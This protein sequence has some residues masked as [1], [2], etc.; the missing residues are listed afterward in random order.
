MS[1]AK[2][3]A[4][5]QTFTPVILPAVLGALVKCGTE[6][7]A[8]AGRAVEMEQIIR[9][10][11]KA[12][13]LAL[14]QQHQR[15]ERA[16]H[17]YNQTMQ[18]KVVTLE[19]ELQNMG[20]RIPPSSGSTPQQRLH[21]L[22]QIANNYASHQ[23]APIFLSLK[24]S[25]SAADFFVK[26]TQ[27]I[28]PIIP[29]G[30]PCCNRL[31]ELKASAESALKQGNTSAIHAVYTELHALMPQVQSELS[32][33]KSLKETYDR[34]LARAKALCRITRTLAPYP[35]FQFETAEQ[36]IIK[37]K[38]ISARQFQTIEQIRQNPV[39]RMDPDDRRK[40]QEAVATRICA[41]LADTGTILERVS[42]IGNERVCWYQY[43][44]AMLKV[45]VADTGF[46]SF[47][48]VGHPSKKSGFKKFDENRV[49]DA[50]NRFKQE[51]PELQRQLQKRD[52]SVNVILDSEPCSEI[53]QY[54]QPMTDAQYLA[55]QSAVLAMMNNVQQ[56]MY[57]GGGNQ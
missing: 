8:Q 12:Y 30:L 54:E 37:L 27:L 34:E 26:I 25:E 3:T 24:E 53:V 33:K 7:V 32:R 44:D 15:T 48:V 9:E 43:G 14:A 39:I 41:A 31:L 19:Q 6:S 4:E 49:L 35:V 5:T 16:M 10:Y 28:D 13:D 42:E 55:N 57:A 45:S 29:E 38:E 18:A 17:L 50:M 2:Y 52:V 36:A 20:I 47:E 21:Q 51:F 1:G 22:S 11:K 56:A 40:A 23:A 46:V